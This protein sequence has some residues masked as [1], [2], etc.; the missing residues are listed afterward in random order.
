MEQRKER[1][2][3]GRLVDG[4]CRR[5]TQH[6][7]DSRPARCR[8]W[9]RTT[10]PAAAEKGLVWMTNALLLDEA[11]SGSLRHQTPRLPA[12]PRNTLPS[13]GLSPS[14]NDPHQ[15]TSV[16]SKRS[17]SRPPHHHVCSLPPSCCC[18]PIQHTS[19]PPSNVY[20]SC[21]CLLR[22]HTGLLS[23][24]GGRSEYESPPID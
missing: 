6:L 22:A 16:L 20:L 2:G 18:P 19:S 1:R 14:S 3:S 4:T 24:A 21:C 15:L 9:L 23:Q 11:L 13:H 17:L 8:A 5:Q 7:R 10:G 12:A